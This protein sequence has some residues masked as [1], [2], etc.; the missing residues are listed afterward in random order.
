VICGA[1]DKRIGPGLID[2]GNGLEPAFP[3]VECHRPETQLRRTSPVPPNRQQRI[4][5]TPLPKIRGG[6]QFGELHPADI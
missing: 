3:V 4:L 5:F 6:G 2:A 1:F